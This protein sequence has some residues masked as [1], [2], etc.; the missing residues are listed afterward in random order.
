MKNFFEKSL[1]ALSAFL[2][3]S[4]L[5][6]SCYDDSELR[7][8]LSEITDRVIALE[9][10]LNDELEALRAMIKGNIQIVSCV[11]ND[12]QGYDVTLSTGVKLTINPDANL[13]NFITYTDAI[14]DGKMYWAY[15]D[16]SGKKQL[17]LDSNKAPIPVE[18]EMPSVVTD[19]NGDSWLVIDGKRYPFSGNSVF[20]EYEVHMDE[21]TGEV[22]AVTFTFGEDMT[23]TVTVD[24]A[25]GLRFVQNLGFSKKI[26]T[27]YFVAPGVTERVET[28][29]VGVV[30]FVIQEPKGWTVE[31]YRDEYN[32]ALFFDITAPKHEDIISGN[33]VSAGNLKIVVVL[34]GG[35]AAIT[36][37]K[38]SSSA[39]KSVKASF[40]DAVINTFSGI[41]KYA[42]G[43][44]PAESYDE[45]QIYTTALELLKQSELTYP[46]GYGVADSD[47]SRPLAD[48]LGSPLTVG[49]KYVLWAV[50]AIFDYT[51]D[52][53]AIYVK[54]GTLVS[55]EFTAIVADVKVVSET[56]R[57]ITVDVT[58]G[59]FTSYYAGLVS[60]DEFDLD[61]LVADLNFEV[62]APVNVTE[63]KYSGSVF[64]FVETSLKAEPDKDYV[65]WIAPALGQTEFS[66]TDVIVT[67]CSTDPLSSGG[68]VSVTMGAEV[69]KPSDITVPLT[70]EGAEMIFYIWETKNNVTK[71][72]DDETKAAR[73]FA[74]GKAVEATEVTAA[75]TD[76]KG[77]T[78]ASIAPETPYVLFTLAVDE[79]GKYG[80]VQTK[81]YS[82]S[83]IRYNNM[84]VR[85]EETANE[86]GNVQVKISVEGG[87]PDGYLYWVGK[88]TSATWTSSTAM[89]GSL[90]KA[91]QY[92]FLN[93]ELYE[94]T[95][96]AAK[97]PVV[98]G[99]ITMTDLELSKDYILVVMAKDSEGMY[100]KANMLAFTTNAYA[101]GD[102]VYST[103]PRW[104]AVKPTVTWMPER[105]E[106]AAGMMP[107]QYGFT[108]DAPDDMTTYVRCG[109]ES[110]FNEGD[111]TKVVPVKDRMLMLID[112]V[113]RPRDAQK[114]VYEDLWEATG[115]M[116]AW[117]N[118]RYPHGDPV[119]GNTVIF[120]GTLEMHKAECDC[121]RK[122]TG[123]SEVVVYFAGEP[124][125]FRQPSAI[126]QND[127]DKVYIMFKDSKG[128]YYEPYIVDVPD[129]YFEK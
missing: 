114:L 32:G 117:V 69:C 106:Q 34:E 89:G 86:P 16:A 93:S 104:T 62:Y 113:D 29:A 53:V 9:D 60:K 39:F 79:T 66:A 81:E 85:L 22:Y 105:F 48:I 116:D 64:G 17:L 63:Q 5:A 14:G 33:A 76:L 74:K 30:D 50:P 73:L 82:T 126:A 108:Y 121:I 44:C 12:S 59:G 75:L 84:T 96:I 103:D 24:G 6:V 23:F 36:K 99:V 123:D 115:S 88:S 122:Y 51:S 61:M 57:D 120:P 119:F 25:M 37:I 91:Q 11:A 111:E 3:M 49:Q 118:F 35:K 26:L 13:K 128:N 42:Y 10:R 18:A 98:D 55:N 20:S 4:V 52:D 46:A 45:E 19:E 95:K 78:I 70:A 38:L 41:A 129:E 8:Q 31:E 71:Y 100:S 2:C 90:E 112:Y 7:S 110:Y 43:V 109:S 21:L 72:P 80:P 56:F 47:L 77:I 101:L 125:E 40:G 124:I 127:I 1:R 94:F 15:I 28:E 92:M 68:S 54:E 87:T 65:L 107:G 97:Y 27:D 102:I 58:L 67:E 83:A